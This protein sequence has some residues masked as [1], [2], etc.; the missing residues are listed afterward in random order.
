LRRFFSSRKISYH[1]YHGLCS[2]MNNNI[3]NDIIMSNN[4][5]PSNELCV[6]CMKS[7]VSGNGI[8]FS[9]EQL[10]GMDKDISYMVK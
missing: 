3:I 4:H 10:P 2:G 7:N 8:K 1:S 9:F 6:A 5:E